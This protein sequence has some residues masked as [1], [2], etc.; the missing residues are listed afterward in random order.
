MEQPNIS[1]LS[2]Y[3][4]CFELENADTSKIY[5]PDLEE[6]NVKFGI[7]NFQA[8]TAK[9][10]NKELEIIFMVDCSGSMSDKCTDGRSK[11]QHVIHTLQNMITFFVENP[12]INV[13]ITVTA[14]DTQIYTIV[15]R[16]KINCDNLV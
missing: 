11:M 2:Q 7:I 6:N 9:E 10:T 16:T 5:I 3:T 15:L 4:I 13:N 8:I 12:K 14:F 1:I